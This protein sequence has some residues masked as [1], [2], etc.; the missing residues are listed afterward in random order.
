MTPCF[1]SNLERDC[2][3]DFSSGVPCLRLRRLGRRMAFALHSAKDVH[4]PPPPLNYSSPLRIATTAVVD[5]ALGPSE[6]A[7]AFTSLLTAAVRQLPVDPCRGES[8]RSRGTTTDGLRTELSE[9]RPP[10]SSLNYIRH[11]PA[12]LHSARAKSRLT[13]ARD[14]HAS[15]PTTARRAA[16][17]SLTPPLAF[18]FTP[19][20]SSTS[21]A[22]G[23]S[24][25][26]TRSRGSPGP[27]QSG[28]DK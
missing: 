21:T 27:T 14:E 26:S 24:G 10:T 19:T 8:T 12:H 18:A 25:E 6:S 2:H 20:P 17:P 1:R 7:P 22:G 11:P 4:P 9:S 16:Q 28:D 15:A 13:R 23:W 5:A 3:E